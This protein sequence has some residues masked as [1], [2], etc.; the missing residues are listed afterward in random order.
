MPVQGFTRNR[1]WALGKQ[2]AH[3]TAVAPTRQLPWRGILK[4][5]PNWQDY[6]DVDVGSIDP[7]LAPFRTITDVTADLTGPLTYDE[8][9]TI[10]AAGVRGGVSPSGGGAAKTWTHQALS[11]SATTLD[12]FSGQ[13]GDDVTGDAFRFWDGVVESFELSFDE[14]LGPWQLSSSWRFGSVNPRVSPVSGLTLG[15]NLPTV[16]GADTALYIDSTAG[17]IGSTQI[18]DALRGATITVEN[19]IDQK[20]YSNGSNSRFQIGGYGLAGRSIRASFV[21]DKASSIVIGSTS[22]VARWLSADPVARFLKLTATSPQLIPGTATPYSW[23]LR[24]AGEWRTRD[25]GE[26]GG[27]STVVLELVGRLNTDLGYALYSSV[28]NSRA[29]LP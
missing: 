13:W 14:S 2:S 5:D 27:N 21:F 7:V 8:L 29:T 24:L 10:F 22:E 16:F 26:V 11:T 3:G 20:R 15:S 18:T 4:V 23:D 25:D 17:G 9:S 6:E 1:A 19:T 28:V 12:E